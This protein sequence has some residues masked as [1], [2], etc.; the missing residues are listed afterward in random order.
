[1][2]RLATLMDDVFFQTKVNPRAVEQG[3]AR[4]ELNISG[5][6]VPL[7]LATAFCLAGALVWA[8]VRYWLFAL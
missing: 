6:Q 5:N 2:A 8:F 1:M 7:A 4:R 3:R